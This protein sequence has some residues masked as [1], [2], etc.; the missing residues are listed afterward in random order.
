[1]SILSDAAEL[2]DDIDVDR[3][4]EA[5]ERHQ[6]IAAR[7]RPSKR[8]WRM[9]LPARLAPRPGSR[10]RH[11]LHRLSPSGA[12]TTPT[13][14]GELHATSVPFVAPDS[15]LGACAASTGSR[16]A[17]TSRYPP[18]VRI[19]E[20]CCSVPSSRAMSAYLIVNYDVDNP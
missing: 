20:P 6:L 13:V 1:M 15:S 11:R 5:L 7:P 4:K 10:D 12:S 19:A 14:A 2:A 17:C 9:P 18:D 16:G 8:T 3:A